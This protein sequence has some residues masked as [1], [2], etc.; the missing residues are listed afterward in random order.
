MRFYIDGYNLM[1][2]VGLIG[3]KNQ[4]S[5]ARSRERFINWV[6]QVHPLPLR[7]V[8]I[9][10][11]GREVS[12][13]PLPE[14]TNGPR[15]VFSHDGTADDLIEDVLEREARPDQVALVSNDRRL[16]Q[17]AARRGCQAWS[18]DDYLEWLECP[19]I[20]QHL[21]TEVSEKPKDLAD[22]DYWKQHFREVD[23][24]PALKRF[25]QPF[26]DFGNFG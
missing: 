22:A 19:R 26:R 20:P 12:R 3:P 4:I 25:N 7:D 18:C 9:V 24:H 23:D 5:L 21:P 6:T 11:D 10:F 13:S 15:I 16:R 17:F 8:T 2:A 1:Y 14:P